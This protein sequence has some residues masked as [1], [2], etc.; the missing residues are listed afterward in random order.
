MYTSNYTVARGQLRRAWRSF[1]D[2][3]QARGSHVSRTR[4]VV[5]RFS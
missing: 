4:I 2:V 1:C 3:A 5:G